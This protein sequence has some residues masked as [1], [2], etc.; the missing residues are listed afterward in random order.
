MRLTVSWPSWRSVTLK[1]LSADA[2]LAA[3]AVAVIVTG[4]CGTAPPPSA[5]AAQRPVITSAVKHWGSFF[6]GTSGNSDTELSPTAVT[7]PGVVAEVGSS[8]STQYALLTDGSLYAWGLGTQG[9]LGDGRQEN[10][11]TRPVQVRFPRGVRI[12]WIPADVMPYDTALAID[13]KGRVWGW[14]HNGGGE[15]C[16]GNTRAYSTPVRLPLPHVTALAGASN[17]AVYD[18][19]GTVYACGVNSAGDLGDGSTRNSTKPVKV[20]GLDGSSVTAL[21]ASYADSG[22]LLSD[23]EYFDWGY[24]GNG[25][26]GDGHAG[27]S[28]DVPV[29]VD[30]RAPV[31]QVAQ[32]G[33]IWHNGQTLVILSDGSVW[34]W[35]DNWAGQLGDG[36]TVMRASPGRIDPP[37]GVTYRSLAT[38]SA[39]SYAV[40]TTGKVYAWGVSLVGQ[41]GNGLTRT[42]L[43]PVLV[44]TGAASISSTANNVV[45][46]V[47]SG[48][49]RAGTARAGGLQYRPP[50]TATTDPSLR[51]LVLPG[52]A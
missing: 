42:A 29:R 6:G 47:P 4:G 38:G 43:T 3:A 8:N 26:L 16:L 50:V 20:A 5:A 48:R 44:A 49:D 19:D 30:L 1:S 7:V 2:A 35:G 51:Q 22:A 40:S 37:A 24:N 52:A 13:T 27:R 36:T 34:S 15:L 12:A 21:A 28:S 41:V 9:Q 25:Q 18:A 23:G 33:S 10:S 11:F 45:I 46:S 31:T 39:T 32:G 14:G 17:H